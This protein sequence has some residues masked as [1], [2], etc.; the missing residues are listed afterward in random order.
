VATQFPCQVIRH[1]RNRGKAAA[2]WTGLQ[3]TQCSIILF[4]DADLIGLKVEHV[5]ALLAPVVE[6]QADMTIGQ[7]RGGRWCTDWSQRLACWMSGQRALNKKVLE[8]MQRWDNLGWGIEAAL[9]RHAHEHG[10]RVQRVMLKGVSQMTKE[11]KLGF[12]HGAGQRVRMYAHI[13]RFFWASS[14]PLGVDWRFVRRWS[15]V[16]TS[17]LGL[18]WLVVTG[19]LYIANATA[20]WRE[21]LPPLR[22][23][24]PQ[25]TL[26]VAPHP[27]DETIACGGLLSQLREERRE[28]YV[29]VLTNGDGFPFEVAR[30][31]KRL[32]K[33][34][35]DYLDLGRRR[36]QEARE[37]LSQLGVPPNCVFFL[38]F[39]DRGLKSLWLSNWHRMLPYLSPYT[40]CSHV[41]YLTAL[42]PGQPY[43]GEELLSDLC[44]LLQAIRPAQVFA[45]HPDDCHPDHWAAAAFTQAALVASGRDL[46]SLKTYLVHYGPWP[47]PRGY[48]PAELLSLPSAMSRGNTLWQAFAL[49]SAQQ[50]VKRSAI[51]SYR[52]QLP[53]TGYHLYS[54]VRRTELFGALPEAVFPYRQSAAF[55]FLDPVRASNEEIL[56][57]GGDC[58][59]LTVSATPSSVAFHL[60]LTSKARSLLRYELLVRAD[61]RS[62][63]TLLPRAFLFRW[64]GQRG[65]SYPAGCSLQHEGATLTAFIPWAQLEDCHTLLVLARVCRGKDDLDHAGVYTV[66][67]RSPSGES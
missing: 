17:I 20:P 54:F 57:P 51:S 35:E 23:K 12:F 67:F 5:R 46:S 34:P 4:V 41:P 63:R 38:G 40:K 24:N 61:S 9:T 29:V 11:E 65:L 10:F 50:D 58:K 28:V 36:R 26:I 1:D 66:H 21:N 6:G 45:P 43:A 60:R 7:F 22:L 37:A 2:M 16:A 27:D 53:L 64:A 3:A 39:P 49:N 15:A 33:R 47:T 48:H 55:T 14:L 59:S 44:A 62:R 42:H 56:I 18:T 8:E 30:E 31:K 13:V 25:R 19:W 32:P 52:S